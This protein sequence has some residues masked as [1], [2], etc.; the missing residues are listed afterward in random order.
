M[1]NRRVLGLALA[2]AVSVASF[3][4]CKSSHRES[5]G[6]P[7]CEAYCEARLA[8]ACPGDDLGTC[9]ADCESGLAQLDANCREVFIDL[10]DCGADLPPSGFDCGNSGG[11]FDQL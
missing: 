11:S 5:G 9:I 2:S 8:A 10:L 6:N 3:I 7:T 4:G 1:C